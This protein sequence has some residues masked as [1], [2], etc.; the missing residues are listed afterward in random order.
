MKWVPRPAIILVIALAIGAGG[1][2]QAQTL[3]PGANLV[4]EGIPPISDDLVA[5]VAPYT[6]FRPSTLVAWHPAKPGVLILKPA[7]NTEQL[8]FVASPGSEPEQWTDFPDAVAGATFQ[9]K[10]GEYILFEKASDG[11]EVFRIF[12]MDIATRA[13]TPISTENERASPHRGI[14][15]AIA[16][17]TRRWQLTVKMPQEGRS[18]SCTLRT[19]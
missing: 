1:F 15:R 5:K 6:E 18:P 14:A 8:Y 10:T 13:V 7:T 2:A 9:P 11:D 3:T 4:I 12:R 19:R 17:F 16:S